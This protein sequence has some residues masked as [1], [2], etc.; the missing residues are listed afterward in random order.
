MNFVC[1]LLIFTTTIL[2][3]NFTIAFE[4]TADSIE[5]VYIDALIQR[6]LTAESSLWNDL[7]SGR[8]RPNEFVSK[9][10]K[11]HTAVFS[12]ETLAPVMG[13]EVKLKFSKYLNLSGFLSYVRYDHNTRNI[14][15]V[16]F[17]EYNST[18]ANDLFEEIRRVCARIFY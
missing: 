15:N 7:K 18:L 8:I 3:N 11:E 14:S 2:V 17:S 12:S 5:N 10:R 1:S 9:I 6:Y 4:D 16:T 13:D